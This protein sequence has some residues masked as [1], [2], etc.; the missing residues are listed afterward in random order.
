[1]N[2][3]INQPSFT[4]MMIISIV[5][6]QFKKLISRTLPTAC[7]LYWGWAVWEAQKW[8]M[9]VLHGAIILTCPLYERA[10]LKLMIDVIFYIELLFVGA[11]IRVSGHISS[12]WMGI[13]NELFL[14]TSMLFRFYAY[15]CGL[16]CTPGP[17]A[18]SS[19]CDQWIM[20]DF[21]SIDRK[22]HAT[23]VCQPSISNPQEWHAFQLLYCITASKWG[24]CW[25]WDW[26]GCRIP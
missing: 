18:D 10:T 3:C 14:T 22:A 25:C 21:S 11:C 16:D 2:W 8:K 5:T 26:K 20:V 12:V 15:P 7:A 4:I 17:R 1:M 19:C 24:W 6:V 9:V 13:G 23:G